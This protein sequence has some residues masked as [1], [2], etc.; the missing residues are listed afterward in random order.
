MTQAEIIQRLQTDP[1]W[2]LNFALD[3][4]F[5]AIQSKMAGKGYAV[6]TPEE[7]REKILQLVSS[8]QVNTVNEIFNVPYNDNAT[9]YTG[10]LKDWVITNSPAPPTQSGAT[11]E[12]TSFWTGLLG[13]VA[14]GLNGLSTTIAGGATNQT[15]ADI[16]AA[17]K[18]E[19][20]RRKRVML[21][22]IFGV[23]GFIL[24]IVILWLIFRKKTAKS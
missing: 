6:N 3:N 4:N 8:R 10:G 15:Q 19:E 23:I 11:R 17:Q 2:A 21:Y 13:F 7:A 24:L 1:L 14:G 16:E 22:W 18:A 9:N 20:E 12:G 5:T